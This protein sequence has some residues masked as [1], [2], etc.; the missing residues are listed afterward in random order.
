M[1][2]NATHGFG[3]WLVKRKL[4][5]EQKSAEKESQLYALFEHSKEVL[6]PTRKEYELERNRDIEYY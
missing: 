2:R 3:K 6:A 4:K 5:L 1:K